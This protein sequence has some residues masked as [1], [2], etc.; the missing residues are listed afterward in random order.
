MSDKNYK[1]ESW[2]DSKKDPLET[3]PTL[4]I[5]IPD[6]FVSGKERYRDNP[7]GKFID[8]DSISSL[9]GGITSFPWDNA[10]VSY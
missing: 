7:H 10:G 1:K 9:W 4:F 5:F 2:F 3:F 6:Y 8:E